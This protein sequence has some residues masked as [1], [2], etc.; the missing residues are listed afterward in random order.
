MTKS[1][2]Q[3]GRLCVGVLYGLVGTTCLEMWLPQAFEMNS[4]SCWVEKFWLHM[5]Q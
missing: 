1:A 3:G 5:G 4:C 2:L